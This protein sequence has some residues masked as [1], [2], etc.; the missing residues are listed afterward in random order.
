VLVAAAL[1]AGTDFGIAHHDARADKLRLHKRGKQDEDL[2][3]ERVGREH[4]LAVADAD[5]QWMRAHD[6]KIPPLT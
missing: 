5:V 3:T 1:V 2:A 4:A 6:M